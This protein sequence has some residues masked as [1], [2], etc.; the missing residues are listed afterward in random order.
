MV[1]ATRDDARVKGFQRAFASIVPLVVEE[2]PLVPRAEVDATAGDL[3]ALT[4]L[5]ARHLDRTKVLVRRQLLELYDVATAGRAA[6]DPS[7]NGEA[8]R[9]EGEAAPRAEMQVEEVIAAVRR[10][11]AFAADEAKRMSGTVLPVAEAKVRQNLW[12]SLLMAL[13]LGV[14]VGLWLNGGRRG[15]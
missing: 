11:E 13:G 12:A 6:P 5:L 9:A 4:A 10:L 2:W 3:E 14:I 1:D 15:R 8:K 7:A